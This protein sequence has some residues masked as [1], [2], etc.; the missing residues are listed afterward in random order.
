ML[1]VGIIKH[2]NS[3]FFAIFAKLNHHSNWINVKTFTAIMLDYFQNRFVHI[4]GA[5][6]SEMIVWFVGLFYNKLF[7]FYLMNTMYLDGMC[8]R[9]NGKTEIRHLQWM[10]KL[11]DDPFTEQNRNTIAQTFSRAAETL[12][13]RVTFLILIL[14]YRSRFTFIIICIFFCLLMVW[15]FVPLLRWIVLHSTF[16][17]IAW[18]CRIK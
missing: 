18:G 3:L 13:K 10:N 15:W 17:S 7:D 11:F 8:L 12:D 6:Y 9:N 16:Y 2:L 1:A 14:G 5:L 4:F